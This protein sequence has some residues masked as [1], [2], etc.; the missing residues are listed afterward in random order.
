MMGPEMGQVWRDCRPS[1]RSS[2]GHRNLVVLEL[3]GDY[4]RCLS[5]PH[6]PHRPRGDGKPAPRF[7]ETLIRTDRFR[8]HRFGFELVAP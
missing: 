8:P 1:S 2:R 4:A 7:R 6:Q 3:A 5:V